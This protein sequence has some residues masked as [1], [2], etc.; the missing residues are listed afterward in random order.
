MNMHVTDHSLIANIIGT[1]GNRSSRCALDLMRVSLA[2]IDNVEVPGEI[3]AHLDHAIELL[4]NHIQ[5]GRRLSP[6]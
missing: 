3:G 6:I 1:L 4:A 2:I 5:A